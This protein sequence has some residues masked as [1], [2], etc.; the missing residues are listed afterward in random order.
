MTHLPPPSNLP[1]GSIVDA[2][3]RDSGGPRQDASTDQQISEIVQYCKHFGLELRK[4][5][6]DVARSGGSTAAREEFNNLIDA[7][8][9]PEDRPNG[10]IL[11]NY[12]RFSRDLDDAVYYKALIRNR[13][14]VV[15]SITDP[16]PDGQYGRIVEFFID[17]SNAEKRRQ[18]ASDAKRGL[19]DL[20]E[21][22]GCVPGAAP[23]GFKRIPV[24]IGT[25]RDGTPR[26]AHRWE[27]DPELI[28]SIQRA[29]D[30][31]ASGATLAQIQEE[32]RLFNS[33]NSYST[34]FT[35]KI[36][37]GILEFGKDLVVENYCDPIIPATTWA[38]VQDRITKY[39][40]NMRHTQHPRRV[41]SPY[42]LSGLLFCAECGAPISGNSVTSQ[43]RR[44]E[45]YRCTRSK[46]RA[47]CT[48]KRLR[49]PM[50]EGVILQTVSHYIANEENLTGIL[51][52]ER[53]MAQENQSRKDEKIKMLEREQK[54]ITQQIRNLTNVITASGIQSVSLVEKLSELEADAITIKY[55]IREIQNT[56]YSFPSQ[57]KDDDII[58][59]VKNIQDVL[60]MGSADE[61]KQMLMSFIHRIDVKKEDGSINGSIAYYI[62]VNCL[63]LDFAPSGPLNTNHNQWFFYSTIVK[64]K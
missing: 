16:I 51:E 44:S 63:P 40:E 30:L 37:I 9:H 43:T 46:R 28:P 53:T 50:I 15:H 27:P 62:P 31:K 41:H 2:Y 13:N 54:K 64:I 48:Q 22:Y 1:P 56:D 59:I 3:V 38:A 5:Y 25:H 47:G 58:S 45:G 32:T 35:N 36:Y 26:D 52:I 17:I 39:T 11:W 60:S 8:R 34:F 57:I 7:T 4:T 49:R 20:V 10:I 18:T 19:R 23:T 21:K 61:I 33:N 55:Q 12:A 24:H 6:A 14:I 29:F 42:I